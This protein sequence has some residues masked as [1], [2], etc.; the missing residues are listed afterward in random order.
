MSF[1]FVAKRWH[2]PRLNLLFRFP[3]LFLR[4]I[5]KIL[6]ARGYMHYTNMNYVL[7][8][9][10]IRSELFTEDDIELRL[11][12]TWFLSIYQYL[13][14]HIWD[15]KYHSWPVELSIWHRLLRLWLW[16]WFF[17]YFSYQITTKKAHCLVTEAFRIECGYVH[18]RTAK[19]LAFEAIIT[20][21]VSSQARIV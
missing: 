19:G 7:R 5:E 8:V 20:H 6:D 21:R 18:S 3:R 10:C 12:H 14:V 16:I 15:K 1:L 9:M 17:S 4:D 13:R 2:G 11:T